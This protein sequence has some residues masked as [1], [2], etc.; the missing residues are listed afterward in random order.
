MWRVIWKGCEEYWQYCL[1][2]RIKT[3]MLH[4]AFR[5]C[6]HWPLLPP[7]LLATTVLATVACY[8]SSK[9]FVP[10]SLRL[11]SCGSFCLEYSPLQRHLIPQTSPPYF[12]AAFRS[13]EELAPQGNLP[14]IYQSKSNSPTICSY[15]SL[16]HL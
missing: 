1:Y 15:S 8:W 9:D 14:W 10:F 7:G 11:C 16:Y 13:L 5:A 3:K 6:P 12:S 2:F 4:F